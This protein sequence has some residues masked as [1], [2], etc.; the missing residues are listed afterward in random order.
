MVHVSE[1]SSLDLSSMMPSFDP[2]VTSWVALKVSLKRN[3]KMEDPE[4]IRANKEVARE[5]VVAGSGDWLVDCLLEETD[6]QV[7][8]RQLEEREAA[9]DVAPFFCVARIWGGG[10][11]G[12]CRLPH[13]PGIDYCE[14][15]QAQVKRQ[16]YLTHGRIDGPIPPKKH[17]EFRTVQRRLSAS[18]AGSHGARE[19]NCEKP[20]Q[21][22]QRSLSEVLGRTAPSANAA[23]AKPAKK[24]GLLEILRR[25]PK[26]AL[27]GSCNLVRRVNV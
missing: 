12:Q 17:R 1:L 7:A 15:H 8:M 4:W 22:I 25:E 13:L 2:R 3:S 9:G 10:W 19:T 5:P 27:R 21:P 26:N 6:P 24:R 14:S 20:K 16:G 23:G 11:G 18:S